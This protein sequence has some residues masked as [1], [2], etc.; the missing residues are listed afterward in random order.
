MFSPV[1]MDLSSR[2]R[3]PTSPDGISA[4]RV[5]VLVFCLRID[6]IPLSEDLGVLKSTAAMMILKQGH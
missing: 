4:V 5:A 6:V 1:A 3:A 2:M